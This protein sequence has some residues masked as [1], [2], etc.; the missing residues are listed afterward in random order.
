EYVIVLFH[1]DRTETWSPFVS[2]PDS[3]HRFGLFATRSPKR[4]NP[5]GLSVVRVTDV[6]VENGVITLDGA[7]AFDGTPVLDVKP[8]LPSVDR[9]DSAK[10]AATEKELGHHDEDTIRDP[11]MYR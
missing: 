2:P 3:G 6:D 10:N 1:F 5:I 7:D 11:A 9:V 8:Y 4:P